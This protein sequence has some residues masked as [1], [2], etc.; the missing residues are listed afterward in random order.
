M[1][2]I[3]N[4]HAGC[5]FPPPLSNRRVRDVYLKNV[6]APRQQDIKTV[7]QWSSSPLC[8]HMVAN[9]ILRMSNHGTTDSIYSYNR[10]ILDLET[11][12]GPKVLLHRIQLFPPWAPSAGSKSDCL[13]VSSVI[14]GFISVLSG[15]FDISCSVLGRA[16][17]ICFTPKI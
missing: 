3:S 8:A 17:N 15:C 1:R 4:V 16:L 6:F 5:R 12:S 13:L 9:A 10:L 14:I 2:A 7:N 11:F